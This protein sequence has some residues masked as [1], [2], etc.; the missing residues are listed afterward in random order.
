M[1]QENGLRQLPNLLSPARSSSCSVSQTLRSPMGSSGSNFRNMPWIF[2]RRAFQFL[3]G[4]TTD[5]QTEF[6]FSVHSPHSPDNA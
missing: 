1:L 3:L 6:S 4:L 5:W 2:W